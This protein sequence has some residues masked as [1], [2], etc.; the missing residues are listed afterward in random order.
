MP[1]TLVLHDKRA[2]VVQLD[3][4][5][6]IEQAKKGR[7]RH[8]E[9]CATPSTTGSRA[10]GVPGREAAGSVEA[11]GMD[12]EREDGQALLTALTTE[13]FTLQGAR[14]QTVGES[15]AR[16]SLYM[17]SVSSTLIALGFVSQASEGGEVFQLFALTVLPTL[18]FLGVFTFVRLVQSSIEDVRYGRAINRIRHYYLELAG[19]NARYFLMSGHD[20]P[21]GVL[22]NMGLEQ[23]SRWQLFFGTASAVSVVNSVVG[24]GGVA[25]LL[26]VTLDL[27]LALAAAAG[28][29]FLA[30]SVAVHLRYDRRRHEQSSAGVE[31]IFPSP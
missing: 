5:D 4:L 28:V 18:F 2:A 7:P 6:P 14:S 13:H 23:P 27:P 8:R 15:A 17:F 24:A 21:G 26:G 30:A 25:I 22:S 16:S 1:L 19:A 10:L 20:D 31:A 3:P 29:A 11:P 12:D 9:V